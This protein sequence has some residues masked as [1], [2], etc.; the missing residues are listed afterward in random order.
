MPATRLSPL[1][2]SFLAVETPS[3][4]MHVGWVVV[5]EPPADRPPPSFV[6]LRD[7][8]AAR[9]CRAPRFRQLLRRTPFG[10]G[11]PVWVDDAGF[12]VARHVVRARDGHLPDAVDRFMSRPLRRARPL[13][14]GAIADSLA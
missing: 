3:A 10:L 9:L 6:E 4:H 14:Q 1:D 13:W 8:I 12:E 2:A 11:P 5:F 7:H